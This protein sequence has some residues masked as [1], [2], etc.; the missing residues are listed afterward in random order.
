MDQ[1]ANHQELSNNRFKRFSLE[2]LDETQIAQSGAGGQ[3]VE[4]KD[5]QL[6]TPHSLEADSGIFL[7]R[8]AFPLFPPVTVLRQEEQLLVS[9]TCNQHSD[10]LC[11]HEAQVLTALLRKEEFGVFFFPD[12]RKNKLRQFGAD[13]GLGTVQEPDDYFSVQW[14]NNKLVI[15]PKHAS[16]QAVTPATL[17]GMNQLLFPAS[18]ALHQEDPVAEGK[19]IITVFKQHKYN[20]HLVTELYS[21]PVSKEG[22]IKN[23]LTMIAP[24]DLAWTQD[25]PEQLKF[26]TA[27]HKFQ[28]HPSTKRSPSDLKALKAI[29][30]NPARYKF[31]LH[32][33]EVSENIT[34][35]SIRPVKAALLQNSLRLTVTREG[36]FYAIA[37]KLQL[38]QEELDLKEAHLRLNWFLQ[39]GETLYL[40]DQLPALGMIELLKKKDHFL[41]HHNKFSEF[42]SQL[43]DKLEDKL[44]VDYR[45]LQHVTAAEL[46]ELPGGSGLQRILYLSD[47]KNYVMIIP[48]IRYGDI[49]IPIRTQRL[50]HTTNA[51]G[52]EVILPRNDDAERAF[53]ALLL[54]Q[55]THFEEQ[56]ENDLHYFYLHRDRFL[57]EDW[58]LQ[59]FEVWEKENIRVLGFNELDSNRKNPHRVKIDIKIRTGINWFNADIRVQ[60]GKQRASLKQVYKSIRNQNK[61]VQLDDGTE[62]ILPQEWILKFSDYFNNAEVI[63]ESTIRINKINL[64][65]IEQLYEAALPDAAIEQE[66]MEY[67][68]K[69]E[70]IREIERIETPEGL[71]ATLRP[72]Q[73]EGLNWLNALDDLNFGGC[74]ADDMGLGKSIQIIAFILSQRKKVKNN[75][76][77]LV[78]PGTLVFNWQQELLKFAPDIRLLTVHGASRNRTT[79]DFDQ[80]EIILTTYGTLLS[81]IRFLKDYHFNYA[82]LDESQ[83]IKNPETQRYKA[84]RL[85]NA[86]NRIVITGTPIENNTFDLFSQLSFACPG[87]LGNKQYFRDIFSIPID[88]FKYSKRARELQQKVQPFIMRRT[89]DEVAPELPEK[90]EMVVYC[91]MDEE[92]RGIYDAYEKEFRDY[93]SAISNDEL[94]RNPMNVLKGLTRLRQIC[95]APALLGNEALTGHSSAKIHTLMEQIETKSPHHKILVFSQFVSMLDLIVA[96]LKKRN[97]GFETLTG[98]T[99]TKKRGEI[100]NA[101][102]NNPDSRVFLISLKAGGTGLNLTAADYVYIV[103]PWWNPAVENQAIDRAHRIGQNK[104]VIAIRL[105]CS[106]TV[107]EKIMQMQEN[108]QSLADNLIKTG[109]TLL[110]VLS[111]NELLKL[112]SFQPA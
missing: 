42:K 80:Y 11:I 6:I 23:P 40:I 15:A 61:Y 38:A 17:Q 8:L 84:V 7:N 30:R 49:E 90:T 87:L 2:S 99:H 20:R 28:N 53:T 39:A 35:S 104:K 110:P 12:L 97:I 60:F 71:N 100:V 10:Q 57:S 4:Q 75:T 19:T 45:Y 56:L 54:G 88:T 34:A 41:I 3:Y 96:E 94:K 111:K 51:K 26:Y 27:V 106:N 79:E 21:A 62:G 95:D 89:K 68:N 77:L 85:L 43:L 24:L 9:C 58:F 86:R 112:L 33:A 67:R 64:S 74:L 13:Y 14:E 59:A 69:L 52:K 93:V 16:L 105:I 72:Y 29:I 101:F 82:F 92:Q 25:D 107:E 47:L 32:D 76:N 36:N 102:Q 78:V 50:V 46:P 108:K 44:P 63:D 37:G 81:D 48:V 73:L 5:Y 91:E 103:D 109:N 31:Y 55:H 98:S 1:A 70:G 65:A 66:I 22:K 18:E 83:H